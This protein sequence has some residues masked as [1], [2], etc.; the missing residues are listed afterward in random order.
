[1]FQKEF[2]KYASAVI[3]VFMIS[4]LVAACGGGGGGGSAPPPVATTYAIS[5]T[6]TRS[7]AA[8]SGVTMNLSGAASAVAT[9]D[10]SGN[11][12]FAGLADGN[13]T[14]TPGKTGYAFTPLSLAV[15]VSGNNIT[16]Q[17]FTATAST[18]VTYALSGKVT[19]G[20]TTGSAVSGVKIT[21]SGANVA[22]T[23]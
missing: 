18:A 17:N 2:V 7:G 13:Y 9:T 16:A 20:I 22:S 11:Y 4:A 3:M 8:L 12:S 21:L 19:L 1:M 15:T 6:A 10:V 5:G 23:S 14:V